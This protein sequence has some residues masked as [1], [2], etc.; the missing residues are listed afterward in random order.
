[1]DLFSIRTVVLDSGERF[2]LLVERSPP[3]VPHALVT[4]FV[5]AALRPCGLKASTLRTRVGALGLGL[6]FC[7]GS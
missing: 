7:E 4:R 6:E 5:L 2:R 1:M 3:G